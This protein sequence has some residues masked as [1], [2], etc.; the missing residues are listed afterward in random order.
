VV[1]AASP[2]PL[3]RRVRRAVTR[4][5]VWR[6]WT[7]A[8]LGGSVI[9]I[10]N[11]VVREL[12]YKDRVGDLAAHQISTSIAVALFAAYF[13]AL[14]RRWPLPS[15]RTA[16]Q[17]GVLWVFLT[18]LFEFG[19]GH[20]IDHKSWREL[21]EQYDVAAGYVWPFLLVWIVVGPSVISSRRI[22]RHTRA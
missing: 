10:A 14:N 2:V 6:P 9:G 20:W 7:V 1:T 4:D 18:L 19:F 3:P 15:R 11:G 21:L 8:W 16:L 22:A 17:V 5:R 13:V 12:A